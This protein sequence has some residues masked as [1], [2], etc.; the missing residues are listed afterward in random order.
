MVLWI[1]PFMGR[2]LSDSYILAAAG[3]AVDNAFNMV[4]LLPML[5]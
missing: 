1:R 4:C 5:L 3:Q 2:L